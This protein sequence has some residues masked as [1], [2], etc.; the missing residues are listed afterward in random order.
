MDIKSASKAHT[1]EHKF[2]ERVL[3]TEYYEPSSIPAVPAVSV[4]ATAVAATGIVSPTILTSPAI[5]VC[6][7]PTTTILTGTGSSPTQSGFLIAG[8]TNSS[9]NVN[10]VLSSATA[11]TILTP[12]QQQ[13][14][15]SCSSVSS[16]FPTNH[17]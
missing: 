10:S 7:T 14:S 3:T 12:Q 9:C 6:G 17:G 8:Q 2:D 1:A 13:Y 16:R 4:V 5:G 11:T 15:S